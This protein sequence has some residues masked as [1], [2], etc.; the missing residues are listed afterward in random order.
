M[1]S[2]FSRYY[3]IKFFD[4]IEI[5]I[6]ICI[7]N[8]IT[9]LKQ[10]H[11]QGQI[12][13]LLGTLLP[14]PDADMNSY[15]VILWAIQMRKLIC[16]V[17]TI[18]QSNNDLVKMFKIALDRMPS[19]NHNIVIKADKTIVGEH[20]RG[21]NL[22]TIDAVAFVIVGENFQSKDIVLHRRN[23]ELIRVSETHRAYDVLQYP[24]I[25]WKGEDRY[26][27]NIKMVNQVTLL[28]NIF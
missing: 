24:L 17:L 10:L 16:V 14:L 3:N 11:I 13:H 23:N 19:D 15:K 8:N 28:N 25:F 27:F 26:H 9:N 4:N 5:C 7:R 22:P 6:K 2:L 20:T 21:F 18:Q 1:T 12:Y